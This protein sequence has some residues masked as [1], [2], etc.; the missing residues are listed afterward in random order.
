MRLC[1]TFLFLLSCN[2]HTNLDADLKNPPH[3][4]DLGKEQVTIVIAGQHVIHQHRR[5]RPVFTQSYLVGPF[6]AYAPGDHHPLHQLWT[7]GQYCQRT[8][9]PR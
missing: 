4:S 9:E 3:F 2:S 8:Q 7:L 5:P 6:M 1:C